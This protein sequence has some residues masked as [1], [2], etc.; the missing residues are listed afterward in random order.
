MI[1]VALYL[2]NICIHNLQTLVWSQTYGPPVHSGLV[3]FISFYNY[4]EY[5]KAFLNRSQK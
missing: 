1:V 5:H 4:D 3:L 2:S